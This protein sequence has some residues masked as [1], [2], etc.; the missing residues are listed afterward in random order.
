[1]TVSREQAIADRVCMTPGP[2]D[3]CGEPFRS[4]MVNDKIWRATGLPEFGAL[5]CLPCLQERAG[6]K[7]TAADFIDAPA[8]DWI[9]LRFSPKDT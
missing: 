8:N 7:L 1:M 5:V 3:G 9:D 2:C 4:Y 6:R